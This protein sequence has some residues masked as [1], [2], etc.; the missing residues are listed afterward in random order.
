MAVRNT[1]KHRFL[2]RTN[3]ARVSHKCYSH[4]PVPVIPLP[5]PGKLRPTNKLIALPNYARSSHKTVGAFKQKALLDDVEGPIAIVARL[6]RTFAYAHD[7]LAGRFCGSV[8]TQYCICK[9]E[10]GRRVDELEPAP[11]FIIIR[12]IWQTVCI[13]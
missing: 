3:W 12:V 8:V 1:T 4:S 9:T 10:D 2:T 6:K 13:D 5:T 11:P 7:P